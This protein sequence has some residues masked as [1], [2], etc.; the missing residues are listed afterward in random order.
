MV[1]AT[2]PA[3]SSVNGELINR[4]QQL[5]LDRQLTASGR[6]SGRGSW[7]PWILCGM[8]AIAWAGIGVRWYKS[9]APSADGGA[10]ARV[11]PAEPAVGSS[12]PAPT[13]PQNSTP[14]AVPAGELLLNLR[15]ILTPALQINLSPDDVSGVVTEIYFK[16]GDRVKVGT[17]LAKIRDD[18]YRNEYEAAKA[19]LEAAEFRYRELLPESVR[20]IEKDQAQAEW[21]EA[22]AARVR[23]KQ[24]WDRINSQK[25]AVSRQDMERAEADLRAATA[26]VNRLEKAKSLLAEGP[27]RERI[28][29]ARAEL[30]NAQAR[31]KE[32]E[33][34]L[35]NCEVRAPID[36]TIL[37]KSADKGVLVSPMSFNVASGICSMADLSDLEAEVE[38]REDQIML[39]REGLECQVSPTANPARVYR[40][41]VDRIMPIADDTK[42][43]IKVRVKIQLPA[44]EE[45][46]SVLKP[47]MSSTVRMYNTELNPDFTPKHPKG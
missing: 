41:R 15:G 10:K 14:S 25:G 43:I 34:L 12:G 20:Q 23:A 46:G 13:G 6:G 19:S 21:E 5:R 3:E 30:A 44:T 4:V 2:E 8:M 36:G 42:N 31:L 40:G 27:R 37:T 32:A 28:E 17:L 29:A 18:R 39:V 24:E 1:S 35:A 26:R 16:E 9:P 47:K 38:V 11:S 7:L 45:P 33:R 22:E